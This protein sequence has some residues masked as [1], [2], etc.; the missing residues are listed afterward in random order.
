M[1]YRCV[2]VVSIGRLLC[3]YGGISVCCRVVVLW[4]CV[5][6]SVC[7]CCRVGLLSL[8]W[9]G[10]ALLYCVGVCWYVVLLLRYGAVLLGVV[11]WCVV[12]LLLCVGD[13]C[14]CGCAFV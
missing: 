9:Y 2:V 12:V 10:E 11:Y 7:V 4:C 5:V 13:A 3:W 8:W 1:S 6:D 14:V